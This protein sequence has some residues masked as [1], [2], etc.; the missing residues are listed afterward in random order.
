[1][2]YVGN[3]FEKI[4]LITWPTFELNHLAHD[5]FGDRAYVIMVKE[6]SGA[7]HF[8]HLDDL[9]LSKL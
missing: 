2:R 6:F 3:N 1:M 8:H 4:V 9:D 5:D 7:I